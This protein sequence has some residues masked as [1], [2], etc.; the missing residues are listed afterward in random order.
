MITVKNH[1]KVISAFFLLFLLILNNTV[2][3]EQPLMRG[4]GVIIHL[5]DL[6][7]VYKI[8]T[9]SVTLESNGMVLSGEN[10]WSAVKVG[11]GVYHIK[12]KRWQNFLWLIDTNNTNNAFGTSDGIAAEV[13]GRK[14]GTEQGGV[15]D[16]LGSISVKTSGKKGQ[17]PQE[18]R[19]TF[20]PGHMLYDLNTKRF[21]ITGANTVLSYGEDWDCKEVSYMVFQFRRKDWKKIYW[22]FDYVKGQYYKKTGVFGSLK[23]VSGKK[24]I[25]LGPESNVVGIRPPD[26][27][28]DKNMPYTSVVPDEKSTYISG[29]VKKQPLAPPQPIARPVQVSPGPPQPVAN[30]SAPRPVTLGAT[31]PGAKGPYLVDE[32]FANWYGNIPESAW[33]SKEKAFYRNVLKQGSYDV[34]VVPLQVKVYAFDRAN[35]SLITRRLAA[36]IERETGL[37]VADPTLVARALGERSRTFTETEVYKLANELK[38]KYL[39]RMYAGHNLDERLMLTVFLHERDGNGN[40]GQDT[41]KQTL[42]WDGVAFSDNT[43]PA[44]AFRAIEPEVFSKLRLPGKKTGV[45]EA[46]YKKEKDIKVPKNFHAVSLARTASPVLKAYYL[47][48]LGVLYP[49]DY[50]DEHIEREQL[51]ERSVIALDAVSPKSPDYPLLKARAYFYLGSRPAALVSL[52]KP[53]TPEEKALYAFINS[54][55]PELEKWTQK[56][57]SPLQRLISEIELNDLRFDYNMNSDN[58]ALIERLKSFAKGYDGWGVPLLGRLFSKDIWMF[59]PNVFVKKLL[60]D[61]YPVP[62]LDAEGFLRAKQA[63]GQSPEWDPELERKIYTHYRRAVEEKG[64]MQWA[65]AWTGPVEADYFDLLYYST[66]ANLWKQFDIVIRARAQYKEGLDLLRDYEPIY[67]GN[68]R[69]MNQKVRA[70][71]SL[72]RNS[73]SQQAERLRKDA[74]DIRRKLCYWSQGE[75]PISGC[76]NEKFYNADYPGQ[77]WTNYARDRKTLKN[78]SVFKGKPPACYG[79]SCERFDHNLL[80]T[81]VD[82]RYI[83]SYYQELVNQNKDREAKKLLELNKDRFVGNPLRMEFLAELAKKTDDYAGLEKLY[84][85]AIAD[86]PDDFAGYHGLGKFYLSAGEVKKAFDVFN[87]YRYFNEVNANGKAGSNKTVLPTNKV[88]LSNYAG[89]TGLLFYRAGAIDEAKHFFKLA[90]GYG[91]GSAME[92][93]SDGYYALSE[94]DYGGAAFHFLDLVNRYEV[95][96]AYMVYMSILHVTGHQK[97]AWAVLNGMNKPDT[98]LT[99]A[100]VGSRMGGMTLEEQ[101]KKLLTENQRIR[102]IGHVQNYFVLA[103]I[104][105]RS[106]DKRLSTVLKEAYWKLNPRADRSAQYYSSQT[107]FADAYYLLRTKDYEGAYQLLNSNRGTSVYPYFAMAGVMSGNSAKVE[108]ELKRIKDYKNDVFYYNLSNAIVLGTRNK[109][110]EA[111]K[112][113]EAARNTAPLLFEGY[114]VMPWYSLV[115]SCEW[116]YSV[117]GQS[118]YRDLAL[119]YAKIY[120]QMMPLMAWAYA[121]EA[122]YTKNENDRLRALA[123]TLYLDKDSERIS[124]VSVAE[125]DKA[126]EWLKGNN[127]FLESSR[128]SPRAARRGR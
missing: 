73:D 105:D 109:H 22:E 111:L 113:L 67:G 18:I 30:F 33:I 66:E 124:G 92:M 99:G 13:A 50:D 64:P 16:Y 87:S 77:V 35:R 59:V 121:V 74:R 82:F 61:A 116:L 28:F 90:S 36:R 4:D 84:R 114:P 98:A 101:S 115:E 26:F 38:V 58:T 41:V 127:P 48:F 52:G 75:S 107:R 95:D 19:L 72:S 20:N 120:Q 12:N 76:L 83:R 118:E 103:G 78:S 91:T 24:S 54:N 60:D 69:F 96:T 1:F 68:L 44:E 63:L 7:V 31:T 29:F 122:K 49:N 93:A 119:K 2:R 80:Y 40:L 11:P 112:Y 102:D 88:A 15:P 34:L 62:G 21:L 104:L 110:A 65:N 108:S 106:P 56:I 14:F 9:N 51:F 42:N 10:E 55:L 39:V 17:D 45:K 46:F 43:P 79:D 5:A 97:D 81:H 27:I 6:A 128:K 100:L 8:K 32:G 89:K 125:K 70:L 37:R 23:G 94:G 117:T 3:A 86:S 53:R 47:Q 126:L 57:T 25:A 71:E 123:I 85:Q